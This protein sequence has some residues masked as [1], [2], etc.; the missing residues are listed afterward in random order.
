M[1]TNSSDCFNTIYFP[2]IAN[3]NFVNF[4]VGVND[5]FLTSN[6]TVNGDFFTN[7]TIVLGENSSLHVTGCF[8]SSGFQVNLTSKLENKKQRLFRVGTL[9]TKKNYGQILVYNFEGKKCSG[10]LIQ[11]LNQTFFMVFDETCSSN[12]IFIL[13][14]LNFILFFFL[15][16]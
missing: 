15:W 9:C 7:G 13:F 10:N 2:E 6:L 14:Y 12:F 1:C 8:F 3:S 11:E 4:S 5:L 16:E